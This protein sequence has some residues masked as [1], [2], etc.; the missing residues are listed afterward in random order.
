MCKKILIAVVA[1]VVGLAV[2]KG[3]WFGSHLKHTFRSVGQNLQDRVSPEQEISRLR[4]ELASLKQDDE[5]HLD[6]VARMEV[7]VNKLQSEINDIK[8][9]L[10]KE[11]SRIRGLH[12]ELAGSEFV[13]HNG[14]KVTKDELRLEAL[15]FQAAEENFKSK[16]KNLE[17]KKKHL[18]IEKTKLTELRTVREKMATELQQMETLLAEE[19]Q[20]DATRSVTIDDSKYQR[21]RKDMESVKERIEVLRKKRQLRGEL[22]WDDK[23][24]K[25]AETNAAADKY[26]EVRFGT[27]EK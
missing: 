14:S 5:K 9:N 4:M 24:A 7:A 13:V 25:K 16:E 18:S 26:L 2:V 11:E 27:A 6:K 15:A 20:A 1:I 21:L 10:A 17:A 22:G 8:T 12:T 19:R 3:T 23:S